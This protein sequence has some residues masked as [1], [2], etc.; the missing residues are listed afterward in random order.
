M[1]I[2]NKLLL[3]AVMLGSPL[4]RSTGADLTQLRT[5]VT[6]K[7]MM[8]DRRPNTLQRARHQENQISTA[9]LGTMFMSLLMGLLMLLSFFVT[10]DLLTSGFIY[11]SMFIVMLSLTLITDF[12][13]VLIDVRDNFIILPKPVSGHTMIL[14]RVL[15][16]SIHI[17]KV[18]IPMALPGIVL[19]FVKFS[20]IAGFSFVLAI[21]LSA[22]F[23]IFLINA[24]YLLVLRITTPDRFQNIISYIQ[25]A[26]TILVYASYQV[27]PRLF[28]KSL[29]EQFTLG[30]SF[31]WLAAPPY[32]YGA[33]LSMVTQPLADP[34]LITA[35]ILA[36]LM[37]IVGLVVVVKYFAPTF[38]Q[39]LSMIAGSGAELMPAAKKN[40]SSHAGIYSRTMAKIF[41]RQGVERESFLFNWKQML[42]SREFKMKV[43]PGIGYLLVLAVLPMLRSKASFSSFANNLR[44]G[45][46]GSK[47]FIMSMLYITGLLV[48]T[49]IGQ[50]TYS[51]KFKASWIFRSTP[52]QQPGLLLSGGAKA[53]FAQFLLP[54]YVLVAAPLW[55]I[56]GWDIVVHLVTSFAG[57]LFITAFITYMG[58]RHLPW[59]APPNDQTKGG[60]VFKNILLMLGLGITGVIH[61]V[62][63]AYPLALWALAIIAGI[64]AF[65]LFK[66][67]SKFDWLDL[68]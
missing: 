23:S 32:W 62:L 39:K 65:A 49:A 3:K 28:D 33:L 44:L 20:W 64:S 24:L 48:L 45:E 9:T 10:T 36:I 68:K 50:M 17:C 31:S 12:T 43:Y 53:A 19:S 14:A 16:I 11:F 15:H 18:L 46:G 21:I 6:Y 26:F 41:T 35:A 66:S 60:T 29:N 51:D 30:H 5:I 7:L 56:N 57:L 52:V 40:I 34:V 8:D 2:V 54:A 63:F 38:N 1:N 13:S 4:Y 22:A 59:S 67:I 27:V 58:D 37:P 47:F 55:V 42:R 25:I 61:G